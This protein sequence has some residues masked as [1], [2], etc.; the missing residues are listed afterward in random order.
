MDNKW[1]I[2]NKSQCNTYFVNTIHIAIPKSS[3]CQKEKFEIL[4]DKNDWQLKLIHFF[5]IHC[6]SILQTIALFLKFCYRFIRFYLFYFVFGLTFF[7]L[8]FFSLISIYSY[9]WFRRCHWSRSRE[10]RACTVPDLYANLCTIRIGKTCWNLWKNARTKAYTVRFISTT[11][12]GHRLRNVSTIQ[13]W[14]NCK[15]KNF[16]ISIANRCKIGI[17]IGMIYIDLT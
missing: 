10:C 1:S 14:I 4:L 11:T 9:M 13:L 17:E 12:W 16:Q 7:S 2:W 6:F 15:T 8:C 5:V 3:R